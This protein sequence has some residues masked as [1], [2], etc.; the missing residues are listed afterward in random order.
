MSLTSKVDRY[1]L[2]YWGQ[3][4]GDAPCL[5]TNLFFDKNRA[6]CILVAEGQKFTTF[7]C[8]VCPRP[9]PRCIPQKTKCQAVMDHCS[10]RLHLEN[11]TMHNQGIT[12]KAAEDFKIMAPIVNEWYDSH[13]A[14]YCNRTSSMKWKRQH[15]TPH[16]NASKRGSAKT[17]RSKRNQKDDHD[18]DPVPDH[19]PAPKFT[20]GSIASVFY[21]NGGRPLGTMDSDPAAHTGHRTQMTLLERQAQRMSHHR[22]H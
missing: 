20:E 17:G 12:N 18:Y 3:C 2:D 15:R 5:I 8:V 4:N 16:E 11:I 14:P 19:V 10:S 7:E 6:R 13:V 21:L 22:S 1:F 9:K